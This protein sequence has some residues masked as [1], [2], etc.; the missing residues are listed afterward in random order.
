MDPRAVQIA[1]QAARGGAEA[2]DGGQLRRQQ[3]T[4]LQ[5]PGQGG[6]RSV[7]FR[8]GR[9]AGVFDHAARGGRFLH[10]GKA[11]PLAENGR[12]LLQNAARGLRNGLRLQ[13]FNDLIKTEGFHILCHVFLPLSFF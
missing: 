3:H 1:A 6:I 2:G 10:P 5:R 12:G 8:Q 9:T 13:L 4:A 7:R 11:K